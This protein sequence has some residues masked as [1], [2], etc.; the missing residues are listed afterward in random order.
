[1]KVI[2]YLTADEKLKIVQRTDYGTFTR[3]SVLLANFVNISKR[4]VNVIDLC[5]GN[6]PVAMLLTRKT[7]KH[8]IHIDAVEIQP[9]LC[10]LAQASV[11]MNELTDSVKIHNDDL[12][13]I[14]EKLG[15]NK[16]QLLTVNP[17]Y[18][19]VDSTSNINPNQKVALAR[20]EIAVNLEQIVA[21]SAKLLDNVGVFAC[22]FRPQRLDELIILLKK[23]NFSIKRIQLIYPKIN[24]KANTI[25][26]EASRR[27]SN[28]DQMSV[29]EPIIVY[30]EDGNYTQQMKNIINM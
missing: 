26:V 12:I 20:H 29:E 9:E 3:D 13:G 11:E 17:P 30:D 5:T 6:A 27:K 21:E 7:S 8:Q 28:N 18:F 16:Y 24:E 25:L 4:I 10:E 22:V 1:M 19:K 2:N 14:S 15:K 23:Y